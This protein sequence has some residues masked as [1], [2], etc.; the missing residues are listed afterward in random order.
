MPLERSVALATPLI[1]PNQHAGVA[2]PVDRPK[3]PLPSQNAVLEGEADEDAEK[4]R[5]DPGVWCLTGHLED[6]RSTTRRD[7]PERVC[8]LRLTDLMHRLRVRVIEGAGAGVTKRAVA[9]P[10]ACKRSMAASRVA[11]PAQFGLPRQM[12]SS[13]DA[14][15]A[16]AL[17]RPIPRRPK[18]V[19]RTTP[20]HTPRR[21]VESALSASR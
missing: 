16:A 2:M 10:S 6:V 18:A 4:V 20:N 9:T 21:S 17:L 5:E 13:I 3:T 1:D 19:L 7:A 11:K 12:T 15:K 8:D 14:S